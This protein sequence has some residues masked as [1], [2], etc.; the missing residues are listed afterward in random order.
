LFVHPEMAE[1]HHHPSLWSPEPVTQ[2][3]DQDFTVDWLAD[4]ESGASL[5]MACPHE[6]C[7]STRFKSPAMLYRH[8]AVAGHGGQLTII[9]RRGANPVDVSFH[10]Q[11]PKCLLMM[12]R[13]VPPT[14]AQTKACKDNHARR[15]A[16]EHKSINEREI[17]RSPFKSRG[18]HLSKVTEF[19]Y[20]GRTLTAANNDTLAVHHAIA[21]AKRKWA[22]LRR[23]LMNKPLKTK[24]VVRF[25]KA[26]VLNVLLYGCETWQ[27]SQRPLDAL[28]AFHNKC[29]RTISGQPFQRL[30]VDGEIQWI[31]PSVEPLLQATNLST[32]SEY[33]STRQASFRAS[34]RCRPTSE[35][36]DLPVRSYLF[37]R[38]LVFGNE[39]GSDVNE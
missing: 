37:K 4:P 17:M 15:M 34:Y 26:I 9:D 29:V 30:L 22:E 7:L 3:P 21:K 36:T 39:H 16:K 32:I 25:Y 38:K 13:P 2:L 10:H 33:I 20:L 27:L 6:R 28:E 8:W 35:R 5:Y 1:T 12:Q 11:C 19:N 24:T 23:I 14:H 18:E 31:R